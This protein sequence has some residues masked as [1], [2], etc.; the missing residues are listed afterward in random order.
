VADK[1]ETTTSYVE[2]PAGAAVNQENAETESCRCD[3]IYRKVAWRIMPLLTLCYVAAMIDRSSISLAQTHM[4][5]DIG[6]STTSYGIGVGIFFFG[7][8]LFEIP[9][10]IYLHR[11]GV[12]RT[13]LRIMVL[14]GLTTACTM[15]VRTDAH[16]YLARFLLGSAEAGFYPGVLLYLTYWFP[17]GRR[18]RMASIFLLG[19]PISG[20]IGSP[21]SAWI[22]DR[23]E[24]VLSLHGWQWMFLLQ[25]V[26]T[27]LLGGVAF[28]YLNDR[29]SNAKWLSGE[30][31]AIIEND[32]KR[33]L[34]VKARGEE[35]GMRRLFRDPRIYVLGALMCCLYTLANVV[36][37]WGPLMI[38][39]SGVRNILNVGLLAMIPPT[40]SVVIMLLYARHSDRNGERR[41]HFVSTQFAGAAFLLLASVSYNSPLVTVIAIALL[42]SAHFSASS[43]F[44]AI[45]SI[46]LP[47][48]AKAGGIALINTMGA[49]AAVGMP[50]LFGRIVDKTGSLS[51]GLQISA[52]IVFG[53][54]VLFL[55]C[56]PARLL[57]ER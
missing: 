50:I 31:K 40:I 21:S 51:V 5:K 45:P 49:V 17:P 28:F 52:L 12:R 9:S 3:A 27:I 55:A 30:E 48:R 7:Y 42:M 36:I 20:T 10:N 41:W 26:P 37:F 56:I 13:L 32:L 29:P 15:F 46:Y 57:R 2:A 33:E 39:R 16:F 25:G 22:I 38:E 8:I 47:E 6:I 43:V 44:A 54:G 35:Y 4:S 14:W 34:T 18:A 11:Y 24:G 53:G 19:P 23:M 1:I